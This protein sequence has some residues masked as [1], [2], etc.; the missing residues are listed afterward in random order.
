VVGYVVLAESPGRPTV[1]DSVSASTTKVTLQTLQA[2]APW[3]FV[4][5]ARSATGNGFGARS[6]TV[7][8]A[9]GDDGYLVATSAGTV[10]G[11]G[12]Q[13]SDGGTGGETLTAPIVGLAATPNGLGYWLAQSNGVVH[14]F[15][16]APYLGSSAAT[17]VVGIAS[18]TVGNQ[19]GY[20]IVTKTGKVTAF[21][22]A[23]TYAGTVSGTITGIIGTA[24]GAGYWLVSS[25]GDVFAFGDAVNHGNAVSDHSSTPIVAIAATSDDGGYW[26]VSAGGTIYNFGDAKSFGSAKLSAPVVAFAAAPD[27]GGY[28]FATAAGPK[29]ALGTAKL[30]G[31]SVSGT[32]VGMA[33]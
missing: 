30:V 8:P 27:D 2:G 22:S 32:V 15:G 28:W 1:V 17:G 20:W 16:N 6:N 9:W 18:A 31:G 29:L 10:G 13:T 11:F 14:A 24:D 25:T 19:F 12:D 5:Y 33:P 21:G 23:V 7:S 4:V 26:L 3:T